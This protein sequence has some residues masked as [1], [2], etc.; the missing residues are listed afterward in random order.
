MKCGFN[1]FNPVNFRASISDKDID[2]FVQAKQHFSDCYLMSTLDTLS[3]TQNGRKVLKNQLEYD[4]ENPKLIN[5]YLYKP[6]GEKEKYTIPAKSALK[7]YEK[8]YEAQPNE[9]IRSVDI[10]VGEYEKKYKAKPWI[11]RVADNFKTYAF[12]KNL[13]SHFMKVLTGKEPRVIA[14]TDFN[15]DLSGYRKEAYELFERMDKEK[16][17]SFVIGTGPKMLDG[18]TW[19]VYVIEDV[20]LEENTITVKEKRGNKPRKMNIDTALNTFKYITGYFDSDLEATSP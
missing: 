16:Q 20:N 17:H 18:R 6:D 10:S 14:E 12:E 19:H 8:L 2:S 7:G 9:I 11:C 15:F 5:C 3:H 1:M 13:P 4:D